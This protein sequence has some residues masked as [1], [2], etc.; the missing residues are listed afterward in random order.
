[1]TTQEFI[2]W[3]TDDRLSI[4]DT[5]TLGITKLR[6]DN[7][8]ITDKIK[9]IF[10]EIISTPNFFPANSYFYVEITE[11]GYRCY[12]CQCNDLGDIIGFLIANRDLKFLYLP[13]CIYVDAKSYSVEKLMTYGWHTLIAG[14]EYWNN[15][16]AFVIFDDRGVLETIIMRCA[17]NRLNLTSTDQNIKYAGTILLII[18]HDGEN[19]YTHLAFEYDVDT[20][21]V[22]IYQ[23]KNLSVMTIIPNN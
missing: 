23:I 2:E 1:M 5:T 4:N 14:E 19:Q 6:V 16:S 10:L 7:I 9:T 15:E 8:V 12:S 17:A 13:N 11:I 20:E 21:H 18:L 22:D 3:L